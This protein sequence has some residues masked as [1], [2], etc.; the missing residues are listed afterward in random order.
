MRSHAIVAAAAV[1]LSFVLVACSERTESPIK[2]GTTGAVSNPAGSV[3][4]A[5]PDRESPPAPTPTT[6][7][8]APQPASTSAPT[9]RDTPA[10]GPT[11]AMTPAE[12]SKSMPKPGQTDNHFTP[13]IDGAT[14]GT[15]QSPGT[16]APDAPAKSETPAK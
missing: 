15:Q 14:K 7:A 3:P 6:H 12:E 1:A 2:T 11:T 9:A 4:P 16:A 8:Q 10:S 13:S 5:A